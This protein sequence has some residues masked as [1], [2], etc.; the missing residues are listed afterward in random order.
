MSNMPKV[1][2]KVTIALVDQTMDDRAVAMAAEVEIS[3]YSVY[4]EV[5]FHPAAFL[6]VYVSDHLLKFLVVIETFV[7]VGSIVWQ[8]YLLKVVLHVDQVHP[9]HVL[10]VQRQ[11]R[12]RI[13]RKLYIDVDLQFLS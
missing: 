12:T 2:P 3:W 4:L 11:E 1:V 6:I 5:S 8:G 7:V 9:Q 10:D 13:T